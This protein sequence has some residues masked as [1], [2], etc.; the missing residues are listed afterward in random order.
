MPLELL[1]IG[2][3][4]LRWRVISLAAALLL[5]GGSLVMLWPRQ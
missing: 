5:L 1:L 2:V 3:W 4:R